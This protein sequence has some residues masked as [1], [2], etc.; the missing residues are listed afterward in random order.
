MPSLSPT[1]ARP[2][3]MRR[4]ARVA[5]F[6]CL[7]GLCLS[8]AGAAEALANELY[9]RIPGAKQVFFLANFATQ[10]VDETKDAVTVRGIL[11]A[12]QVK[13]VQT[14]G[15]EGRT[16]SIET[17]SA[18]GLTL[19][20][21]VTELR[22]FPGTEAFG[23][24]KLVV[25]EQK[26]T[27]AGAVNVRGVDFTAS[28]DLKGKRLD[29][30]ATGSQAG[31]AGIGQLIPAL[32]DA[33]VVSD[34]TF[35]QATFD[36][37]AKTFTTTD[38]LNQARMTALID[39]SH[40][41]RNMVFDLRPA[42]GAV[43]LGDAIPALKGLPVL[44][45]FTLADL[46]FD[47]AAKAVTADI[48][49]NNAH[50]TGSATAAGGPK[51]LVLDLKAANQ[52]VTLGEVLPALNGAPVVDGFTFKDLRCDLAAKRI[53][54][55][56]ALN[57]A[58]M[59]ATLDLAK[60][61]R[62]LD[63]TPTSGKAT[64]G[65]AIPALQ[66]VPVLDTFGLE[67]LHCD[68]DSRAVTA[69]VSLNRA[70]LTGTLSAAQG[71]KD[72]VLDLRAARP[73]TLADALAG[74]GGLPVV[75]DFT[76]SDLRCDLGTRTLA[77][78]GALNQAQMTATIDVSQGA[79]NPAFD[80][81]PTA[82]KITPGQ[83]IPD[84][85][86]LPV[87]D[88][89][90]LERLRCDLGA[91]TVTA[92]ASVNQAVLAGGL[93]KAP[94]GKG[95]VLDLASAKGP[96]SLG[97]V[98]TDLAGA[99]VV[100]DFTFER[101]HADL[102]ARALSLTG[103][104]NAAEM[105]A[106]VDAA[107][108]QRSIDF[109][110]TAGKITPVQAIPDLAGLPV[111]DALG[112]E[113]LHCDV[114]TRAV[115]ATLSLNKA[116]LAGSVDG[117][118]GKRALVF[119]LK[120][121]AGALT[122][123]QALPNL[124]G[125]AVV[126]DFAFTDL[127]CD[128][129]ARTLALTG[130]L[131]DAQ[132]TATVDAAK[133]QRS[134]DFAATTGKVTLVQVF[135]ALK[136][137]PLL[138]AFG[139][140]NLHCDLSSKAVS[141]TV[142]LNDAE[143]AGSVD[144]AQG[145][146][147]LDFSLTA[148]KGSVTLG[149]ALPVV[150]QVPGVNAFAL[151]GLFLKDSA[152]TAD[153]SFQKAHAALTLKRKTASGGGK[154]LD[155]DLTPVQ[156]AV[157]DLA[158]LFPDLAHLPGVSDFALVDLNFDE[159]ARQLTASLNIGGILATLRT[160]SEK[161][162]GKTGRVFTLTSPNLGLG[163]IVSSLKG[164]PV[165]GDLK[166]TELSIGPGF[167]EASA[168]LAGAPI[169]LVENLAKGFAALDFGGLDVASVVPSLKNTVISDL[170]MASSLFLV[171]K[172]AGTI[173]PDDFPEDRRSLLGDFDFSKTLNAGVNL[174]ASLNPGDLGKLAGPLKRLGL[175]AA[176][177]P[178]NGSLPKGIFAFVEHAFKNK[179]QDPPPSLGASS[180]LKGITITVPV[181]AP[182]IAAISKFAT[183]DPAV[184]YVSG[185]LG[186]GSPWAVLP[187]ELLKYKPT[188]EVDIAL[189]GG[190]TLSIGNF[191]E[192]MAALVDLNVG[193][194][195]GAL[196]LLALDK[197][198]WNDPFGIKG[199]TVQDGGY[200]LSLSDGPS[201]ARADL[202]FFGTAKLHDKDQLAVSAVFQD[203]G[204]LPTLEYF[205]IAGPVSLADV[206]GG[207]KAGKGCILRDLKVY[208][209][210][211]EAQAEFKSNGFDGTF[212]LY[213]FDLTVAG[214]STLAAALDL[215]TDLTTKT[216]KNFSLGTLAKIAPLKG[217][218]AKLVTAKLDTMEVANA[219]LVLSSKSLPVVT[220]ADL[221][222]GPAQDLFTRI[223][224]KT[225][226]PVRLDNVTLLSD[227]HTDMMGEIG[228]KL[229]KG[230]GS[231]KL[232]LDGGAVLNG[233][234]GGLF[235]SDPL[236]LDLEILVDGGFSLSNLQKAG[237]KL[238]KFLKSKPDKVG[239]GQKAGLIL[240]VLDE[241]CEVGL[242]SGFDVELNKTT[243]DFTGT[244]GVQLAEEDIGLSL[245]GSM[246]D[247]WQN[248]LGIKG[249]AIEKVVV[250][251]EVEEEAG[252]PSLKLG[253]AGETNILGRD[254]TLAGDASLGLGPGVPIPDGLG[255]LAATSQL[256]AVAYKILIF[257]EA[258]GLTV[259]LAAAL[260]GG[261]AL[262]PV[263]AVAGS[264]TAASVMNAFIT[265]L[266]THKKV[267]LKGLLSAPGH[268][269]DQFCDKVAW[270]LGAKELQLSFATP[271]A[272]DVNLGIPDGIHL[273]G[274]IE[275]FG[276]AIK[277]P[278]L[279]FPLSWIYKV[280]QAVSKAATQPA[281]DPSQPDPMMMA[282]APASKAPA[283]AASLQATAESYQALRR[284]V[285]KELGL[286]SE[287]PGVAY[288]KPT[289][290]ELQELK[291]SL[292]FTVPGGFTLGK[293]SFTGA[294][295][296]LLHFSVKTKAK[297][298]GVEEDVELSIRDGSLAMV[299]KNKLGGICETDL[300]FEY[301]QASDA[302]TVAADLKDNAEFA[303]WLG[304]E[305]TAGI[306]QISATANAKF[307]ALNKDLQDAQK[308]Q[309][310]A[311]Q[312]LQDAQKAA[313][314]V[315]K[316]AVA[317]LRQ[318]TDNYQHDYEYAQSQYNKCSGW[319]KK[320]CQA[321]WYPRK[322]LAWD[323]WQ[324]SKELLDDAEKALAEEKALEADVHAAQIKFDQ[325]ANA[326]ALALKDVEAAEEIEDILADGLEHFVDKAQGTAEGFALNE[327]FLVGSTTELAKGMPFV[328][329]MFFTI[330]GT[331]YQ[332]FFA[333]DPSSAEFNALSFG[334]LPIIVAEHVVKDLDT[335]LEKK[336]A[337]KFGAFTQSAADRLSTWVSA[338]IYELIG[339]T[340]ENMEKQINN[341]QYEL[342]QEESVYK[343]VFDSLEKHA[344]TFQPGYQDLAATTDQILSTYEMTDFMPVS[345]QF[346]N[347]YIAVGHS[348]LCLGVADN[349]VDVYQQNC[350]D[351]DTEQWT[352][353]PLKDDKGQDTGYVQLRS[354]G[355]CLKAK[356]LAPKSGQLL[357]LAQ[358]NGDDEHEK[359]KVATKDGFFYEIINRFSQKCLHFDTENA[360]DKSGYAVWTS[361][362][363]ADSQAFRVLEDAQKPMFYTVNAQVRANSGMCLAPDDNFAQYFSKTTK[364]F[365]TATREDHKKMQSRRHDLLYPSPCDGKPK[366]KFNYVEKPDGTLKL[367]HAPSGWCV[368]TAGKHGNHLILA[369]CDNGEDKFW[370]TRD[371]NGDAFELQHMT[372]QQCIDLPSRSQRNG[373]APESGA[374][375]TTPCRRSASQY[376]DFI[377]N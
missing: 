143:M 184:L 311:E 108:G 6:S 100:G 58:E 145:V 209:D 88:A 185:N 190:V 99:P 31:K 283:S 52:V 341:I 237:L 150:A 301:D 123:G 211:I 324:A 62:S 86:G 192:D 329:E 215:N 257:M 310:A 131:N 287:D 356:N 136:D 276:G 151:E 106:S 206:A 124:A 346:Q 56:G 8:L 218:N 50:L 11:N 201:G 336:L 176:K 348:A 109:T 366:G 345:V 153:V 223:F 9:D 98:L 363:G 333:L 166:F 182:K 179:G 77:L 67:N 83:A 245:T 316:D 321:K 314:T 73:V 214:K 128:L 232:G 213:L 102:G 207:L 178:L 377:H 267:T 171:M 230:A 84:L 269:L 37:I 12:K 169:T 360:N 306:K 127:R 259:G 189:Q 302:F 61:E 234:V 5:L 148:T 142:S 82:G 320:F 278:T 359:W 330:G 60:A 69:L 138:D 96:V 34:F 38:A 355:L 160:D 1:H 103:K 44:D 318:S 120:A 204:G 367:V 132:M 263:C 71:S 181:G 373:P 94:G 205:E 279:H 22:A 249:F 129:G 340:R 133:G 268:R 198:S 183:L 337:P 134:I 111:M 332:E 304:D 164:L 248:A 41:G 135:P 349:G 110:A 200:V 228:D 163:A 286:S 75:N 55:L 335:T 113:N 368:A 72:L 322:G 261:I 116:M 137:L 165:L 112:L 347:R 312:G 297:L 328:V 305:I 125:V 247:T 281:V 202:S 240:K 227:F 81:T 244:L 26:L 197:G 89:F 280:A 372:D 186:T 285:A 299:L 7:L 300:I 225:S 144:A 296:D 265:D 80:L 174:L 222:E 95:V 199:L 101:L 63:L 331:K 114:S 307:N 126:N 256:D 203:K 15:D 350:K 147:H 3:R 188:G 130:K 288:P 303:K 342:T 59:T 158:S 369:P 370:R 272:S 376:L 24:E 365:T 353:T 159:L 156:G 266:A 309:K 30:A 262:I 13:V 43:S 193:E 255:M 351:V 97:Q 53:T 241:T 361:C 362:L 313:Q 212:G 236:S 65:Q 74:L 208:P 107:K 180:L 195:A 119:D 49:Y 35:A 121:T 243:F 14:R 254:F 260:P 115:S 85:A 2:A 224:G 229:G 39:A 258:G 334:L 275:L 371:D 191:K 277:T 78:T 290:Q 10:H 238:P 175:G 117:S 48:A 79:R 28:C 357:S 32:K 298:F 343:K 246:S 235:D 274:K 177:L 105:T 194:K 251:G 21:L 273:S 66:G 93:A 358:C 289:A 323:T 51:S 139:L 154:G 326:V 319:K 226:V 36:L 308:V 282:A 187:K 344:G 40:G 57:Q 196:S 155:L 339:G 168:D 292:R 68:L 315:T 242:L 375:R 146:Q 217:K 33:P 295:V 70:Q 264:L 270:L 42:A 233:A 291:D 250:T 162:G 76:F 364:G 45:N 27:A 167:I 294:E 338:H 354:K 92:T 90:G 352:T 54:L 239:A 47:F 219:C 216:R 231:L 327:A 152:F 20:D 140:E 170:R 293:V 252:D 172:N 17:D 23:L 253:L 157:F 29:V 161:T 374:A 141:A 104:I 173:S 4:T 325:A 91:K 87:L 284:I 149:D 16:F 220:L 118:K 18:L 46:R 64:P 19:A 271:G 122:L 210:G 25:D 317:R 221:K